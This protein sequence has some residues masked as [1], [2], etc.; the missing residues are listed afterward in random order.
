MIDPHTIANTVIALLVI[1]IIAWGLFEA[2][3]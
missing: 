1:G 3:R 2:G